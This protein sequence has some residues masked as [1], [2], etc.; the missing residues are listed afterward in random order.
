VHDGNVRAAY[1]RA[2]FTGRSNKHAFA[3]LQRPAVQAEMA[4]QRGKVAAGATVSAQRVV[5]EIARIALADPRRLFDAAG[6]LK[7]VTEGTSDDAAC[8]ASVEVVAR[9]VRG[10]GQANTSAR[11]DVARIART[12]GRP[13][14][15][16]SVAQCDAI[17]PILAER[18][19]R[20]P[21]LML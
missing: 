6:R 3:L 2:G 13:E 20:K 12:Q 8:I 1:E 7:P 21:S 4:V 10:D 19:E 15:G 16:A 14:V 9:N 17:A 18:P 5:E 11:V